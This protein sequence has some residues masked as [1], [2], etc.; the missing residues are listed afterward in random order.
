[1][2]RGVKIAAAGWAAFAGTHMAMSHPGNREKLI[3]LCGS[4]GKYRALYSGVSLAIAGVTGLAYKRTPVNLRGDVIPAIERFAKT[5]KGRYWSGGLRIAGSILI[6]DAFLTPIP[7]PVGMVQFQ[8]KEPEDQRKLQRKYQVFGFQRMSRHYE[9]IGFS[10]IAIGFMLMRG[11]RLGDQILL[12]GVP[13]FSLIGA[14]HQ[15][16]HSMD[17]HLSP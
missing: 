2:Q 3:E 16:C 1:M 8:S 15:V 14:L 7:N 4:E 9:F 11:R 17:S 13:A 5:N 12:G 10:L 6:A